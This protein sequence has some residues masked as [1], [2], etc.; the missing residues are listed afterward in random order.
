MVITNHRELRSALEKVAPT[1]V[2]V[3]YL[4]Y[5][6]SDYL[7]I[8]ALKAIIV[9]PTLGSNPYALQDLLEVAKK[10]RINVYFQPDLHA[11]LYIGD[12]GCLIGSANLS[13]NGFSGGLREAAVLLQDTEAVQRARTVFDALMSGAVTDRDQQV[14]MI[15]ELIARWQEARR[16]GLLANEGGDRP[17]GSI[18]DWRPGEE[19]VWLTWIDHEAEPTL[20]EAR[21]RKALP[22]PANRSLVD[23]FEDY[24]TL[25]EDDDIQEGDWLIAWTAKQD[26]TPNLRA[27]YHYSPYWLRVDKL[28]S[29]GAADDQAPYTQLAATLPGSASVTPPFQIEG[30]AKVKRLIKQLLASR[31]YPTLLGSKDRDPWRFADAVED[32]QRFLADLKQAY[33]A[34]IE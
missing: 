23:Y 25:A 14:R 21:I 1:H 22:A 19:R 4:G 34:E 18:L 6:W 8:E 12:G 9:S 30:D 7:N 3:A 33:L 2:A 13:R 26:G 24:L 28:I 17:S 5:G 27:G 20:N 29:H 15:E 16:S 32:N 11:K 31:K 10:Q